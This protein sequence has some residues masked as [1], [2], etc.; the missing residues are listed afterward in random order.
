[1]SE[2]NGENMTYGADRVSELEKQLAI[3]SKALDSERELTQSLTSRINEYHSTNVAAEVRSARMGVRHATHDL[4]AVMVYVNE[5]QDRLLE[6]SKF[7]LAPFK[8]S[9]AARSIAERRIQEIQN[10]TKATP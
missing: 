9:A 4:D 8:H 10:S 6:L 7:P 5:L 2:Q 1:M 3:V